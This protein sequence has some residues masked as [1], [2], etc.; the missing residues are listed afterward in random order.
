MNLGT[1][2]PLEQEGNDVKKRILNF[3]P[4]GQEANEARNCILGYFSFGT[5]SKGMPE[6]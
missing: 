6:K 2:L 4:L 1:F 5:G 3:S